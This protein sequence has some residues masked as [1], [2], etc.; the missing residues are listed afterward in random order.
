VGLCVVRSKY[1]QGRLELYYIFTIAMTP[2][3]GTW[4]R[5]VVILTCTHKRK[6]DG[7]AELLRNNL[8]PQRVD[9]RNRRG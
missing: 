8:V 5:D 3:S 4:S 6:M 9:V 1:P 2:P 7:K